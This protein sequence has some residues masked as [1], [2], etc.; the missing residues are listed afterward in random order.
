MDEEAPSVT[1]A[2]LAFYYN[3]ESKIL[4]FHDYFTVFVFI[5]VAAFFLTIIIDF[6]K[7]ILCPSNYFNVDQQ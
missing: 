4:A 3:Y 7:C 2:Y 5:F 1:E 6:V